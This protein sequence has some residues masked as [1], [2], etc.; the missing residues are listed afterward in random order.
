MMNVLLDHAQAPGVLL[1]LALRCEWSLWPPYRKDEESSAC[2]DGDTRT[3]S[4]SGETLP[5]STGHESSWWIRMTGGEHDSSN[6][7]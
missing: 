7:T 3:M 1:A 2:R 5:L 4:K 6:T